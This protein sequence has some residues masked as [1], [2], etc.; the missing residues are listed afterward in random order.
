M[1]RPMA[2]LCLLELVYA[3]AIGIVNCSNAF[4]I[5]VT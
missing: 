1:G 4:L 2:Q 5:M 3:T